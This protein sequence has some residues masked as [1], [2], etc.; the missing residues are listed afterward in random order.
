[1]IN[2]LFAFILFVIGIALLLVG[3]CGNFVFNEYVIPDAIILTTWGIIWRIG[4]GLLLIV[5]AVVLGNM[6]TFGSGRS[7]Y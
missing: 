4:L 5:L 3:A 2:K 1:M 7:D 6:E